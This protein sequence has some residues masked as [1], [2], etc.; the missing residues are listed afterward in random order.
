M[1]AMPLLTDDRIALRDFVNEHLSR[2]EVFVLASDY[3]HGFYQDHEGSRET[4]TLIINKLITVIA[5]PSVC[6]IR[7]CCTR[8]CCKRPAV[9]RIFG[10]V[11]QRVLHLL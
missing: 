3:F 2:D 1:R 10:R 8:V 9:I 5:M 4:K 7:V 6:S 11:P